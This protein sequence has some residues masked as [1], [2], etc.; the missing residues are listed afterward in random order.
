MRKIQFCLLWIFSCVSLWAQQEQRS[1]C[2]SDNDTVV[3][4]L[5]LPPGE[6]GLEVPITLKF[7][8]DEEAN[9]VSVV[10]ES[11]GNIFGLQ[12]GA[13]YR[14]L[15]KSG[16]IFRAGGRFIGENLDY[17]VQQDPNNKYRMGKPTRR[18]LGKGKKRKNHFFHRWAESD[19]MDMR[20]A[21]TELL[22][23]QLVQVFSLSPEQKK[24]NVFLRDIFTLNHKG[25]TPRKWKKIRFT[26]QHDL[27][28]K[29]ELNI[30][31]NACFGKAEEVTAVQTKIQQLKGQLEKLVTEFPANTPLH[32]MA[33][34]TFINLRDS[35]I[36]TYP[37]QIQQSECAELQKV[38]DQYNGLVNSLIKLRRELSVPAPTTVSGDLLGIRSLDANALQFKA[39]QLDEL[40]GLWQLTTSKEERMNIRKQCQKIITD[41]DKL[42]AGKSVETQEQQHA[43]N[44]FRKA[45]DYYRR[46]VK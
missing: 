43:V 40:V 23:K 39:R 11:T 14:N 16:H 24:A 19:N 27:N 18:T 1:L 46:T 28:L 3:E 29:Y 8:F 44:T 41:A 20:T 30:E 21:K 37:L 4:R 33:Y 32:A 7:S 22:G 6:K 15:F 45:L 10:A 34:E 42:T 12:A 2:L 26:L 35:L 36:S 5:M 31:H 9:T 13:R 38:T 25:I 17:D